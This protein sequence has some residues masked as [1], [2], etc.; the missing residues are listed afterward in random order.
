LKTR[1]LCHLALLA[2]VTFAASVTLVTVAPD[3]AADTAEE[4]NAMSRVRLTTEPA[5]AAG[6]TR[7]GA[8]SDDNVKDLRRK[9]VRAGGNTA[10]ISFNTAEM[11]MLLAEVFRCSTTPNGP[12]IPHP[13]AGAPP[14]PPPAR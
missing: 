2:S 13:P 5:L 12:S 4:L 10:V 9:I 6:C 11:S 14:P 1:T 7:I 8:M 3:A